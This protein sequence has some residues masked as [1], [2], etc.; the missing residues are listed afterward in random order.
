MENR[1]ANIARGNRQFRIGLKCGPGQ[2]FLGRI[3]LHCWR[4]YDAPRK[5]QRVCGHLTVFFRTQIIRRDFWRLHG[6][7]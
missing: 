6:V 3:A 2:K 4:G 1:G 5:T 7:R